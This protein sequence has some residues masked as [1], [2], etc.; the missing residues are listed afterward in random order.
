MTLFLNN[1]YNF[2]Y[3]D[4]SEGSEDSE[5]SLERES[6]IEKQLKNRYD[7]FQSDE[8]RDFKRAAVFS[9][10]A[11]KR[12]VNPTYRSI[13][14]KFLNKKAEKK[15]SASNSGDTESKQIKKALFQPWNGKRSGSENFEKR[16]PWGGQ[17][18]E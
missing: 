2:N 18:M 6:S 11:G 7:M 17:N 4:S 5:E 10:W 15:S 12:G 9:A 8:I 3:F 16:R 14:L 13:I 1:F